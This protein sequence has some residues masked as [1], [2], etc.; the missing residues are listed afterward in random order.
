M[1]SK[2]SIQD[3]IQVLR[4]VHKDPFS[5]LGMHVEE[6]AGEDFI[7]VRTFRPD[8][9]SVNLIDLEKNE[10]W[11]MTLIHDDGMFEI[12]LPSRK[13]VFPYQLELQDAEGQILRIHDPYSFLPVTTE[14]DRHLFLEGKNYRIYEK[15]GAQVMEIDQIRGT[16]F[17]VW[18]PNARRVS[19]IGEFNHW[20]GTVHCMRML[21]SSGIWEIFIPGVV[22][23]FKYKYEVLTEDN[24]LLHKADPFGTSMEKPPATNSIVHSLGEGFT[25]TDQEWIEKR[26]G[27][28]PLEE[29]MYIYEVHLGSWLRTDG[30][31]MLDYKEM[32]HGLVKY[33][34]DMGYTHLELLP[35]YEHPFYGSWGYQII[36]Y[37]AA[38]A[39]YG[40]PEDF[41]YLVNH[42]HENN[43]SVILDWVPAHFPKDAH[44]LGYF[45]GTPLFEASDPRMREQRDW[46]TYVYDYGKLE[47]RNFLISNLVFWCDHFHIDGFRLDAVASMLYLDYSRDP[48]EWVPNKFGG[49]ENLEAVEFIRSAN[50]V[51]HEFYPGVLMI[52]EESTSWPGVTQPTHLGGLGFDLKWNLGWMNDMLSFMQ[53]DPLYRKSMVEK[54]TFSI[55][56]TFSENFMLVLSHDEVVHGKYSLLNKMPGDTWQRFANLRLL[57]GYLVAHPGKKL[58]FMGGDIGQ[59][60]EWNHD[61][62]LDWHLLDYPIHEGLTKYQRALMKLYNEYKALSQ[63]DFDPKG[64][65]WID[66]QDRENTVISYMRKTRN[67][68]ETLIFIFNF[69]PIVRDEYRVGV[70]YEGRYEEILNSDSEFFGGSNIGNMGTTRADNVWQHNQP[71]SLSLR[72]P[73]LGMLVFQ[74][75]DA[76]EMIEVGPE[77]RLLRRFKMPKGIKVPKPKKKGKKKEKAQPSSE[78][79][80]AVKKVLKKAPKATSSAKR[81]P[82]V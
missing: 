37:F 34:L 45:D 18:A 52:A 67:P 73:P 24:Y 14:Y 46:G 32:A 75:L 4:G 56:Y 59:Q 72:L 76:R 29:P 44:G 39:R 78:S 47:V 3:H 35:V 69:T 1:K 25:W 51:V 2:R 13:K 65:E 28:K 57:L 16:Y 58:L 41:M 61:Q 68:K 33:C 77:K 53:T 11:P 26:P 12:L 22:E 40:S 66:F 50:D 23:G 8:A 9:Q 15:M 27:L 74:A 80:P 49:R 6:G 10:S 31:Q 64:F 21:G 60:I 63:Y 79:K 71:Y 55:F 19:V 36:G 82:K 81:K 7:T 17:S 38:T 48:G 54:L 62:G 20:E 5:I 30:N 42:C 43:L 70:P